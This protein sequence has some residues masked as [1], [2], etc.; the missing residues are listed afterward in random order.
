MTRIKRIGVKQTAKF[1]T[2]FYFAMMAVFFV[3][4]ILLSLLFGLFGKSQ[5]LF[6]FGGAVFGGVILILIPIGYALFG[7]LMVAA[8]AALYNFVAKRVGG[9][10]VEIE[11]SQQSPAKEKP[12][13]S[14]L[15]VSK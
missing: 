9:I 3:P 5:D 14:S 6:S 2:A 4:I 1:A 12:T 11:T 7:G 8:S 13:T 10:E 15:K